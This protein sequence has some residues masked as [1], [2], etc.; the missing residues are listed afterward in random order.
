MRE[1]PGGVH[2]SGPVRQ[3]VTRPEWTCPLCEHE[4][5][6]WHS[7]KNGAWVFE[8]IESFGIE[9][10]D[11][12]MVCMEWDSGHVWFYYHSPAAVEGGEVQ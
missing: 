8:P 7:L 3:A 12:G 10:P 2:M 6:A 11:K 9:D 1:L 5:T 4:L